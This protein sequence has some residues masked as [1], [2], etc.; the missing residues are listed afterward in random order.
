MSV[1]PY[2]L[3]I[4]SVSRV[5]SQ[6]RQPIQRPNGLYARLEELHELAK[7]KVGVELRR[8]EHQSYTIRFEGDGANSG[9]YF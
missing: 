8:S 6:P 4:M 3:A 9:F 2:S 7:Q 5:E 1:F